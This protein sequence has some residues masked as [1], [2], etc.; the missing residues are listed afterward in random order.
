MSPEQS[1]ALGKTQA[2]A[3][4]AAAHLSAAAGGDT[5]QI[6]ELI[7]SAQTRADLPQIRGRLLHPQTLQVVLCI[8]LLEA[9]FGGMGETLGGL[10]AAGDDHAPSVDQL[11]SLARLG[12]IF[13][14]PAD[15]YESLRD[16]AEAE[17]AQEKGIATRA[18]DTQALEVCGD[19]TPAEMGALTRHLLT[20]GKPAAAAAPTMPG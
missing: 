1:R 12:Y 19:W 10:A 9:H 4:I 6:S 20:L 7:Q 13:T 2:A 15:A 14:A 8:Q 5:E 17:D 16:V 18:L 11:T 3:G